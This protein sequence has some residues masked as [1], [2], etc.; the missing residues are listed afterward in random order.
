MSMDSRSSL[1]PLGRFSGLS[2]LNNS[3]S[4]KPELSASSNLPPRA[5]ESSS[6]KDQK[7]PSNFN[8]DFGSE[9]SRMPGNSA[10]NLGHRRIHS[11]VYT[12]L[13]DISFE[14]D[15]G[16]SGGLDGFSGLD[17]T[18]EEQL[19]E[20]LDMDKFNSTSEGSAEQ[21][22]NSGA[23]PGSSKLG[24]RLTH[25]QSMIVV[26]STDAEM[27]KP[28]S[29]IPSSAE[30]DKSISAANLAELALADPKRA[31]RFKLL[32]CFFL[33][34]FKRFSYSIAYVEFAAH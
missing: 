11:D 18:E 12:L 30:A 27:P 20:Y 33:V 5:A 28:R 19:P 32:L 6:N 21:V 14:T 9:I 15:L 10:K 23:E 31:K 25:S 17:E 1:P 13:N 26:S 8:T 7:I 34:H 29:E 16:F 24:R 2:T 4:A 3:Y 22:T